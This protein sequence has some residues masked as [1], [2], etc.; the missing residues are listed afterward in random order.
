MLTLKEFIAKYDGKFVEVGGS[1]NAINQCVDL[2][3][4]YINEVQGQPMIFGT[5]AVDFPERI[6]DKY[7]FILNSATAFPIEGDVIIFKQ[8]GTRYGTPGHI[9]IVV[10]ADV[11]QVTMFEENYPTGSVCTTHSRNYLGC[12]GWLRIKE[13]TNMYKGYDLSNAESMKVAVDTLVDLQNGLLVRK[14][15]VDQIISDG[16]QKLVDAATTYEKEKAILNTQISTLETALR[17]LQ[18]TEHTWEMEA[19][20][21]QRKLKAIVEIF[22]T[23]DVSLA[24]ESDVSVLVGTIHDYIAV[25]E[26]DRTFVTRV[27]SD[28]SL[29]SPEAVVE[30]LERLKLNETTINELEKTITKLRKEIAT[31]KTKQPTVWQFIINKYFIK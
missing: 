14:E 7:D 9:A 4:A 16:N 27:L 10:S 13:N 12:R 6:G 1:A 5:N 20:N 29:G 25:A 23:V 15:Q 18:D 24:V 3:N 31:L 8:Y 21:K 2:A 22:N 17:T 30:A 11:N 28:V 26:A 19:D